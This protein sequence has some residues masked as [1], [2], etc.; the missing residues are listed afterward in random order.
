MHYL[1]TFALSFLLLACDALDEPT[2]SLYLAVQRGDIDQ[3][4]RHIHWQSDINAPFPDG[5]YPLHEA[6]DKGR[7]IIVQRLLKHQVE[8]DVQDQTGRTPI[9]LAVL[10]GRIQVAQILRGAGAEL[11]A[12]RL[13]LWVAEQQV[14]DRDIVRFLAEQA[15][16]LETTNAQGDTALL[17]AVRRANHRLVAHLIELGAD[18]NARDQQGASALQIARQQNLREIEQRLLRHGASG[19]F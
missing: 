16:D 10:A 13:L 7:A 17:I 4:E 19:E 3:L 6:A 12:S 14:M 18:V 8:L 11:D 9:D 15:A 1:L 2:I 5:R